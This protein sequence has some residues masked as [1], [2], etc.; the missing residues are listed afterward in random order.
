M[1]CWCMAA[2]SLQFPLEKLSLPHAID[3]AKEEYEPLPAKTIKNC[4]KAELFTRL[5][6]LNLLIF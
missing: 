3:I 6:T 4:A 1:H 5:K 2:F